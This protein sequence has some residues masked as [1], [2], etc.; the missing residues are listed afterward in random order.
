[1]AFQG[2]GGGM[3]ARNDKD[4]RLFLQQNR[5]GGVEILNGFFLG[6]KIAVLADFVGVFVM[7]EEEIEFVVFGEVALELF[8]NGLRDLRFFSCRPVGPVP[9]T[10]DRRPGRRA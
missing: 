7:D 4:V 9:C 5:Q 3:I 2:H 10:W 6:G 8:G 1:M